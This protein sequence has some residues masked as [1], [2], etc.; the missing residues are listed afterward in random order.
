MGYGVGIA[1]V[2]V[3]LTWFTSQKPRKPG[4]PG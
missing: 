2:I 3:A 1:L 4:S